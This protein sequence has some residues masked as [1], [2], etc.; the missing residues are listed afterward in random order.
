MNTEIFDLGKIGITLGGEYDNKVIYEKLTIVLYKGKSYISTKTTQGISPEQDILSWQLVAEAKDAY[1]MLV[2]AGKTN[3]TEE[4]FLVQLEDAT[5][6]RYLIQGNIINAADEEDLTVEHSALLGIDTLKLANRDNTNGMGYV[7]LRKNKSFSEQVTNE[8]TI[9]EIRY[10]FTLSEDITIPKN[11]ILKFNGGS[12]S[13]NSYS[14]VYN[15]T[16]VLGDYFRKINCTCTGRAN[17][18]LKRVI[19]QMYGAKGNGS[20][21]DTV[22]IQNALNAI[23]NYGIVYIP[24]G[25]YKLTST[26]IIPSTWKNSRLYSD[27]NAKLIAKHN[28]DCLVF[29]QDNNE[30]GNIIIDNLIIDGPNPAFH[31]LSDFTSTGAG[32][33]LISVYHNKFSRLRINGFKYGIELIQGIGNRFNEDCYPRFNE[34]GIYIHGSA[35][36]MN[37]FAECSIRENYRYGVHISGLDSNGAIPLMNVISNCLIESNRPYVASDMTDDTGIGIK[38]D[39]TDC[40]VISGC[41]AENNQTTI[42]FLNGTSSTFVQNCRTCYDIKNYP[43]FKFGTGECRGNKIINFKNATPYKIGEKPGIVIDTT[44]T[45]GYRDNIFERLI[46]VE[47]SNI[48]RSNKSFTFINCSHENSGGG[49][50]A[51]Q[52]SLTADK[53]YI[54]YLKTSENSNYSYILESEEHPGE[55]VLYPNGHSYIQINTA[56]QDITICAIKGLPKGN[57]IVIEYYNDNASSHPITIKTYGFGFWVKGN[58]AV[59]NQ[60][61]NTIAFYANEFS[62]VVELFRNFDKPKVTPIGSLLQQDNNKYLSRYDGSSYKKILTPLGEVGN[63]LPIL[64]NKPLE[65]TT[66]YIYKEINGDTIKYHLYTAGCVGVVLDNTFHDPDNPTDYTTPI[67]ISSIE[68]VT[69]GQ[70]FFIEMWEHRTQP[71]CPCIINSKYG[72]ELKNG[73]IML[74]HRYETVVF[75]TSKTSGLREICRSFDDERFSNIYYRNGILQYQT[76]DSYQHKWVNIPPKTG[77]VRYNNSTL[78]YWN[79]D[80]WENINQ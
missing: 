21:D 15:S 64:K 36:N 18:E 59:L 73:T 78:Q 50:Y 52:I 17:D 40:T 55:Y 2:D 6:G 42:A 24:G 72:L 56:H 4:E 31:S 35:P 58:T 39:R 1:H 5:K 38:L 74:K 20:A 41:Y 47:L 76:F 80:S 61:T 10:N 68:G 44:N 46:G 16:V 22:A 14:I 65:S 34:V 70:I 25:E 51:H 13:S 45:R 62:G 23:Y 49:T 19:P 43:I 9:Y 67:E 33:K 66:P 77:E 75:M 27:G 37:T 26:L 57:I 8:N 28:N 48:V 7:I 29:N 32:L 11:C 30:N 69:P 63:N 53:E 79:G 12:I 54:N 71:P 3:L 60:R